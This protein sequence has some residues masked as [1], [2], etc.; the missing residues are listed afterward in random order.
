MANMPSSTDNSTLNAD[1]PPLFTGTAA[2]VNVE[3]AA[4][5]VELLDCGAAD[6]LGGGEDDA[7]ELVDSPLNEPP[8]P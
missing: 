6:E 8:A 4:A 2:P 1:V 5:V 3:D 7:S